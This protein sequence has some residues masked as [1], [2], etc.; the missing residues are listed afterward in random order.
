MFCAKLQYYREI[1]ELHKAIAA[2]DTLIKELKLGNE[3][4]HKEELQLALEK[5][6]KEALRD[7]D[8]LT[9]QVRSI[10][11]SNEVFISV[12]QGKI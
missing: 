9:C 10:I 2:K 5:K 7:T 1:A 11:Q 8:H 4:Q 12:E 6:H 3:T